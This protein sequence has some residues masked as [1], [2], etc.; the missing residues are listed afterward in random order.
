LARQF[1]TKFKVF[2]LQFIPIPDRISHD[3]IWELTPPEKTNA[4]L[5]SRLPNLIAHQKGG[6]SPAKG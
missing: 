1:S 6:C 2:W 4:K 3:S 5:Q